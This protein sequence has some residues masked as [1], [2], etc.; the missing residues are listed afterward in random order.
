MNLEEC[1]LEPG[2]S[3]EEGYI[4]P[5][6]IVLADAREALANIEPESIALSVWSP[7]YHVGKEYEKD[8]TYEEWQE[9]LREVIRLHFPIIKPG[10]FLVINIADIL[11]FKDPGMPRI[12]AENIS[13]RRSKVTREQVLEAMEAH[14]DY[15]RYQLAEL[16]GCS[17]QTIDRRLNGNNIRGGKYETQTRVKLVG[18]FI[19]EMATKAG[20]YLYD[21][22]VWVKD[23]AWENSKWHTLSYRAVDQF[24]YLY[25]F[26]KPGITIVDRSRLTKEEWTNWGSLAVWNIP[27]VRANDDHEAKFPLELPRRVI[28]LLTAEGDTVLDCFVG[29]GTTAVAAIL[30]GRYYIGIDNQP[31]YV[32]M[33]RKACNVAIEGL[34]TNDGAANLRVIK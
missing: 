34:N 13:R 33:A 8:V 24:E 15:N 3:N 5:N 1:V 22:R 21:R 16:L 20:F 6:S 23:A 10:A 29:S 19:E 18:G 4:P 30:E 12:Q 28:Q 32:A 17:E 2:A 25:I 26:W 14:P 7:P 11:C 31:Q 27:S 9:L